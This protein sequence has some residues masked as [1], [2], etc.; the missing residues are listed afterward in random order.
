MFDVWTPPDAPHDLRIGVH[1]RD[2]NGNWFQTLLPGMIRPGDWTTY[3]LDLTA[4]NA[5]GLV[6]VNHRQAW[7][8]YSRQRIQEIGLHVYSTHPRWSAQ[9]GAIQNLTARFDNIRGVVFAQTP[10]PPQPAISLYDPEKKAGAT[11]AVRGGLVEYHVKINKAFANPFDPR[12]C[13]LMALVTTPSGKTVRVPAFFDQLCERR[14]EA[15]GGA[16]IVEPYGDEFFTVRFRA[17]ELG[18]HS[19]RFELRENGKYDVQRTWVDDDRFTADG[20]GQAGFRRT[21]TAPFIN[22]IPTDGGRSIR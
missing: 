2:R 6:A 11:P 9:G 20:E 22:I 19:V 17:Q 10:A 18:P 1:L 21:G 3:A 4:A 13:D 12:D 15:P 7:T 8:D 16:E 5:H 14:E